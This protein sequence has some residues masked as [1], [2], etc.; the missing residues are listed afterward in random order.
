MNDIL[1]GL[2]MTVGQILERSNQTL[3]EIN[4]IKRRM[5]HGDKVRERLGHQLTGLSHRMRTLEKARRKSKKSEAPKPERWI[6]NILASGIPISL[7]WIAAPTDHAMDVVK[8]LIE[9]IKALKGGG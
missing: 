2:A 4:G 6:K 9:L 1:T 5:D 8:A 7:I 3:D